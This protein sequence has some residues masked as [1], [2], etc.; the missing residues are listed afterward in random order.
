MN[1]TTDLQEADVL[2]RITIRVIDEEGAERARFDELLRTRA[3]SK[4]L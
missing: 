3:F 4:K 1:F 2:N